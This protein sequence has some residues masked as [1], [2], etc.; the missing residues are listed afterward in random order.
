[1]NIILNNSLANKKINMKILRELTNKKE[2]LWE[3]KQRIH[4]SWQD[5]IE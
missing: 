5:L 4:I 1:M 3:M 2:E